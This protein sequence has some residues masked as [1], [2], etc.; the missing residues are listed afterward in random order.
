MNKKLLAVAVA[1]VFAAPA[2]FAQSS[3]TISGLFK[4]GYENMKY[5]NSSK[6]NSSQNG[7][8][9]DSSRIIFNVKEDLGGGL[10]AV[11]QV[12]MRF[13]PDVGTIASS[14]NTYAGLSSK[15]WG[16]ISWGRRDLHYFN[17]ESNMT[18][19]G[20]LRSDSI[21]LLA[22]AGGGA[23]AI[24]NATRTANVVHYLS[25]N[26]SGFTFILAYSSNPSAQ[27]ADISSGIRKGYAWNFNPNFQ[28]SNWQ[29][30][31]SYWD[32]K[33]DGAGSTTATS[34]P[35]ASVT[36]ISGTGV[37]TCAAG[38]ATSTTTTASATNQRGDRLYGSYVFPFG[39][40]IG[41]AWD[42]SRLKNSASGVTTSK[43][44]VWSLP[45][46]YTWGNHSIHFH[47]DQ[48]NNDKATAADDK[49]R[50]WALSY[51][52]DLSKRTSAA[53]TYAQINN[54]SGAAYN[55]FTSGSL[56]LGN[57]APSAGEDPR[58]F[59]VTLRHAF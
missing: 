20:S 13:A 24:A 23:T 16:T 56:G 22:Y 55:F 21:S 47:Y 45:I 17:R 3:V 58:M 1:G 4:G 59:G 41:L 5:G 11:G 34:C 7:V 42:K 48:A 52:Y 28:G 25:P 38:A 30:G 54:Q 31:Y 2:A 50:M 6:A 43:R 12:D 49:A 26:W 14:G 40:K 36:A 29:V 15:S 44:D 8:V 57:A 39:L 9:D 51:A 18:D 10:S 32:A 35:I 46:S 27:D 19:K 53:V 33:P 37:P